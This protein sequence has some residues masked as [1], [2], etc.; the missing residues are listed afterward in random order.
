[1]RKLLTSVACLGLVFGLALAARAEEKKEVKEFKG[2]VTCAKCGLKEADK[3]E[4]ILVVKDG[5]KEVKY[6]LTGDVSKKNHGTVCPPNTK[7]EATVKGVHSEKDG[8][9]TIEVESIEFAK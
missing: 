3:C 5:D 4:N 6:H 2:T 8:K 7:K 9:H 1:M